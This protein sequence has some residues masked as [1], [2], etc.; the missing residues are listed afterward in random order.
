M[1]VPFGAVIDHGR[2]MWEFAM[3]SLVR[4]Q[5]KE[6]SKAFEFLVVAECIAW[7][8]SVFCEPECHSVT[9]V[10]RT[11]GLDVEGGLDEPVR[12]DQFL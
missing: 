7:F 9:R 2:D 4:K 5:I 6:D 8:V 12:A 1:I 11:L 10:M 3:R